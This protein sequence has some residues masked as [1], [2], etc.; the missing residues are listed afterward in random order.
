MTQKQVMMLKVNKNIGVIL[1][2]VCCCIAFAGCWNYRELDQLAIASGAAMDINA[3]GTVKLTIEVVNI[4]GDGQV[5]YEPKYIESDGT[6]FFEATRKAIAKVG[7]K[8][9]WSHAKVIV[10][11]E[12]LA[13]ES[14]NKYLDF[15]F[16]DAEAREDTWLLIS[17]EKTAGEILQSK[18]MIKPIVSF[19][20]DDT[21]RSQKSISRFPFI[22]MFE[23]F[24][25]LFYKQVAPILPTVHLVEQHGA[26][27]P[28]IAGTAMFKS[29]KLIGFLDD[30]ETKCMLWLRDEVKGGL[31][32]IKDVGEVKDDVTLEIYKSKSKF[33]PIIQANALKIVVDIDLDVSMG[34]IIGTTNFIENP[35][36]QL[37]KESAEKQIEEEIKKTYTMVRDTYNADIFGFGRLVEMKMPKVWNQIKDE[38]DDY[39]AELELDVKVDIKIRGS[40]TTRRPLKVGE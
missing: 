21:M 26:K 12:E 6:T 25:R 39:F 23:F 22:E 28:Q 38:W 2:L 7:K 30:E 13:R 16:R 17:K 9:Y 14:I 27:T 29:Y 11:S 4:A 31:A 18:G 24:D 36:K 33:T 32:I 20:I 19:E 40:A 37:L 34:E 5:N 10:I 15:L 1:I 3:D 8:I 35:G